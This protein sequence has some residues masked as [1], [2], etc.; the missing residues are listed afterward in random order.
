MMLT[1]GGGFT[2]AWYCAHTVIT[3]LN[4]STF[5]RHSQ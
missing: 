1:A 5:S 3:S 2:E 4:W